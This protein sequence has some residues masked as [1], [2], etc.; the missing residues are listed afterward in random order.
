MEGFLEKQGAKGLTKSY[1]RRYFKLQG[2]ELHYYKTDKDVARPR[3][4][5]G[6][7]DLRKVS[8]ISQGSDIPS[9]RSSFLSTSRTATGSFYFDIKTEDRI[10]HLAAPTEK[11]LHKWF[12]ALETAMQTANPSATVSP[13]W[14]GS[15]RSL[16]EVQ[17]AILRHEE[18]QGRLSKRLS[19]VAIGL[20]A[21]PV[22]EILN[23]QDN[24]HPS[25]QPVPPKNSV[26][27]F[28]FEASKNLLIQ[29]EL[30]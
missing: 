4:S 12:K 7:I 23:I 22:E 2:E 14:T 29:M 5:L 8:A 30:R 24:P 9:Q 28:N 21:E 17:D 11:D 19:R 26:V 10:Y 16:K 6:F 13:A 3:S 27:E 25:E 20:R 18:S 15:L 1:K